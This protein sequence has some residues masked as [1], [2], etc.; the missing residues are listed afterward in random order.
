MRTVAPTSVL[1]DPMLARFDARAAEYDRENRFFHEDLDELRAS[2]YLDVALPA[3]FGGPGMS[4]AE[5][6]RLQRR[7]AYYAPATAVAVN[8]HFYWTG[9][10]ADLYRAGDTSCA[11]IL[12]EAAAGRSRRRGTRSAC[13]PRRA[14]TRCWSARSCPTTGSPS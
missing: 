12:E 7:L 8:M 13:A 14:R 5:V 11:W 10:A 3:E 1:T 2:G 9:V 4:L 6:A